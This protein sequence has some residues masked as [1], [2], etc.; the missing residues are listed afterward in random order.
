[1]SNKSDQEDDARLTHIDEKGQAKMVDVGAK[2]ITE[3]LAT[4]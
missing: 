2:E 3:R 1:M 4:P